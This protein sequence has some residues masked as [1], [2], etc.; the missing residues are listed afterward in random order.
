M[1]TGMAVCLM[2]TLMCSGSI[3]AGSEEKSEV[4]FSKPVDDHENSGSEE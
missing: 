2:V 3:N 4:G 1:N